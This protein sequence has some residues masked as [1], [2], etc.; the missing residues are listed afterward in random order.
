MA[1]LSV[2]ILGM[3]RTTTSF[4]LALK[5]FTKKGGK[6][7]FVV[8]G[9]DRTSEHLKQ[10]K[11]MGALDNTESRPEN[12]V[13]D[14]DIVIMA[15]SYEEV[16]FTYRDIRQS[17][18]D[19]V[20]ILDMSPLKQPSLNWAKSYLTSEQH[21]IGMTAI[22][23]PRYIFDTKEAVEEAE[24]DLFDHSAILLTPSASCVKEAVDL[25]FNFATIVGSKPRFLDPTEHDMLLAQTVQLPRILGVSLFYDLMQ[26]RNWE[27]LKWL[28]NPDFGALTRPLFDVHPDG[29]RDEFYEN[30]QVLARVLDTY[31]GTLTE[32]RDALVEDDKNAIEAATVDAS[33][34]YEGWINSRYKADWDV[35]GVKDPKADTG[36]MMQ[37]LFGSKIAEKLSGKDK[38]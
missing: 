30:R 16:E 20:V 34:A 7:S 23:N 4:G 3:N 12:A 37:G 17:L 5:R 10:A 8:T 28:T 14:A 1:N 9:F 29:L 2:A 11:K 6:H 36:G 19:G 35:V 21:L 31:I 15:V 13:K 22:V 27:D 38:N 26:K 24:E 18:R 25:A 33:T 32:F